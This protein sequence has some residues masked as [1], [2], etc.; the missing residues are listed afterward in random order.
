MHDDHIRGQTF[1]SR[2]GDGKDRIRAVAARAAAV[3]GQFEDIKVFEE[4]VR[5][6]SVFFVRVLA[7]VQLGC[8]G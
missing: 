5:R 6:K 7:M 3:R 4:A 2:R 1:P 8:A